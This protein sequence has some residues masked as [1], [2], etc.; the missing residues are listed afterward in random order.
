MN[1]NS[2]EDVVAGSFAKRSIVKETQ[3]IHSSVILIF[4]SSSAL[5]QER[6]Q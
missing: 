5:D 6:I 2:K 4:L 1:E 3:S